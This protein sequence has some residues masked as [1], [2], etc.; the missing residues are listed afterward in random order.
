[1]NEDGDHI[2]AINCKAGKGRTGLIICCYLLHCGI[3]DTTEEAL[4]YYGT[5]RTS[6]GKGVTIASQQRYIR[7]YEEILNSGRVPSRKRLN[8]VKLKVYGWPKL[9]VVCMVV[10]CVC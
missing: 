8:I 7:Y 4:E 10:C 3:C 2:V 5:R 6:N 9:R 1:M